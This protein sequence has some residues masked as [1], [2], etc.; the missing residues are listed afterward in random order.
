MRSDGFERPIDVAKPP[1]LRKAHCLSAGVAAKRL[2]STGSL[3]P[4]SMD[5]L[6]AIFFFI[7]AHSRSIERGLDDGPAETRTIGDLVA[8]ARTE[9]E[10]L[11]RRTLRVPIGSLNPLQSA[12]RSANSSQSFRRGPLLSGYCCKSPFFSHAAI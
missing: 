11:L 12:K 9:H 7:G 1:S 3:P 4:L 10:Q 8:D 6:T 2:V 5:E